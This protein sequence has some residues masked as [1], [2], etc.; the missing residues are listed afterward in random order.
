MA[1][2]GELPLVSIF[3]SVRNGAASVRRA[4]ESVRSQTYPNIE[5]VV[6]DGASTDG[7]LDIL[8]SYGSAIDLVSEPDNGPN[9]GFLRALRRCNGE[10]IG[11]C[12]ADEELLADAVERA[13]DTLQRHP[14]V[15]A[16]TG[17]AVITDLGGATTGFWRSGPFNLVDY[18]LCDY[19]PYFVSSFFRWQALLD[20][21]LKSD[22]W[23]NDCVEFELWC[24][25]ANRNH[26]RY[27]AGTFAKYASHPDQSTN[28]TRDVVTH[29]SGRLRHLIAMCRGDGIIGRDPL[30]QTLAIWGHARTFMNHAV[31]VGR[32]ETAIALYKIAKETLADF[33]PVYLDQIL[34]DENYLFRSSARHARDRFLQRIPEIFRRA[35]GHERTE[36]LAN[37]IERSLLDAHYDETVRGASPLKSLL[38]P[39]PSQQLTL[40][41]PL[42]IKVKA[43]LYARLASRYEA[44][45]RMSDALAMWQAIARLGGLPG[46]PYDSS[47]QRI[48]YT[49]LANSG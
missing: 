32:P 1:S 47:D 8:R 48:G 6:Q 31:S 23:G 26:I 34:Y 44:A 25:L 41:P 45:D 17:D 22:K 9:E 38:W 46:P 5:F 10:F 35:L 39:R 29:F 15:G 42:D 27:V 3:M 40:P 37:R 14:E 4:I 19:C 30:L 36:G 24:R 33:E 13:V 18:L 11:S 12:L 28:N 21:G 7:T 43:N 16:M 2:R 49:H 20:A